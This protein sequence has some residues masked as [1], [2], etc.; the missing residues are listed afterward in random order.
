MCTQ[1]PPNPTRY[2]PPPPPCRFQLFVSTRLRFPRF[3]FDVVRHCTVV[4][5]S[6]TRAQLCELLIT[7]TLKHEM[8]EMEHV[9]ATPQGGACPGGHPEK[10]SV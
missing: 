9:R 2:P 6:I 8:P 3:P 7:S 1:A 4:N 5:F 10:P